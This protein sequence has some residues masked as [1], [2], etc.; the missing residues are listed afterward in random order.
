MNS[1]QNY[2]ISFQGG[3]NNAT[4]VLK[5]L[6]VKAPYVG[7]TVK[8]GTEYVDHSLLVGDKKNIQM[9]IAKLEKYLKKNPN[10]IEVRTQVSKLKEMI[11]E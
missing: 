9:H 1:I 7:K 2:G 5:E 10:D 3:K 6:R 11:K 8:P 4:K